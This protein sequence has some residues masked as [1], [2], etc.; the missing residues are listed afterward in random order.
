MKKTEY[1]MEDRETMADAIL[2]GYLSTNKKR[3][4]VR[5]KYAPSK[6]AFCKLANTV[7]GRKWYVITIISPDDEISRE[8]VSVDTVIGWSKE[9]TDREAAAEI[10]KCL[11]R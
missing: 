6:V 9:V 2:A 4:A 7:K 1:T 10:R 3:I 8:V 5:R 11:S